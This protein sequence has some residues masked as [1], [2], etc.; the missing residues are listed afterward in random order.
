M[1]VLAATFCKCAECF[2]GRVR[3]NMAQAPIHSLFDHALR[4]WRLQA[5][6][7]SGNLLQAMPWFVIPHDTPENRVVQA[8]SYGAA[9]SPHE[10][11]PLLTTA[12]PFFYLS[13]PYH[14][15]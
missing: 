15:D 12:A 14:G 1:V 2:T 7:V 10:L 8:R 9:P 13:T 11:E 3:R 5:K 6:E 4:G